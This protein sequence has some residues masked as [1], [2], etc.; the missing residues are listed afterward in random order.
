VSPILT[1]CWRSIRNEWIQRRIIGGTLKACSQ[2]LHHFITWSTWSK[3]FCVVYEYN[4][5]RLLSLV[6]SSLTIAYAWY[7]LVHGLRND[8]DSHELFFAKLVSNCISQL[9]TRR[10]G[11]CCVNDIGLISWSTDYSGLIFN[12]ATTFAFFQIVFFDRGVEDP[13]H[14]VE[15]SKCKVALRI[16][17]RSSLLKTVSAVMLYV[18]VILN[19]CFYCESS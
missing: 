8:P 4:S 10:P 13:S 17:M 9:V 2:F 1:R 18:I 14:W 16:S 6:Q 11:H 3:A 7:R 15:K 19:G 12:I 5:D